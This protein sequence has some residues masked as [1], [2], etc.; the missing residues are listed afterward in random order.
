MSS[1]TAI[2]KC[3]KCGKVLARINAHHEPGP[4]RF[5]PQDIMTE[6]FGLSS[7][8]CHDCLNGTT[9]AEQKDGAE[10]DKCDSGGEQC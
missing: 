6:E 8:F 1:Y 10:N 4:N 2:I 3:K 7:M 9:N 5:C